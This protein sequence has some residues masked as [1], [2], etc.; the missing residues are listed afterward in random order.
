LSISGVGSVEADVSELA[1]FEAV[2]VESVPAAAAAA[3]VA[4]AVAEEEAAEEAAVEEAGFAGE[5]ALEAGASD[6]G[7]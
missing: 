5:V 3:G 4:G 2:A 1:D 7:D 6:A